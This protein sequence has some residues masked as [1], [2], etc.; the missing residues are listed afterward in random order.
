VPDEMDNN[1][2]PTLLL[3]YISLFQAKTNWES[4]MQAATQLTFTKFW[5]KYNRKSVFIT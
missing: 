4:H 3:H 1:S 2:S 5:G